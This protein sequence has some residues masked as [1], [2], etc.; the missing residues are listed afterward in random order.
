MEVATEEAAVISLGSGDLGKGLDHLLLGINVADGESVDERLERYDFDSGNFHSCSIFSA[1]LTDGRSEPRE[2][3]VVAVDWVSNKLDGR[4][5]RETQ[6]F[7]LLGV[8]LSDV[9]NIPWER[10]S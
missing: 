7:D 9:R 1:A 4:D 6:S 10:R 5:D 8:T 2:Q 3:G